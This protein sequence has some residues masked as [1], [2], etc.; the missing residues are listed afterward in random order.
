MAIIPLTA[1]WNAGFVYDILKS[2]TVSLST[3]NLLDRRTYEEA[4]Y[5]GVNFLYFRMPLR[6]REV[7]LSARVRF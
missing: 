4:L 7:M 3:V 1:F 5:T 6:G 2:F